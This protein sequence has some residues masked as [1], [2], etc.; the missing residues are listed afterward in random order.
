MELHRQAFDRINQAKQIELDQ[1]IAQLKLMQQQYQSNQEKLA[2]LSKK[3]ENLHLKF[4]VDKTA[5]LDS[6]MNNVKLNTIQRM[7]DGYNNEVLLNELN[8]LF[9][10]ERLLNA[11]NIQPNSN[12]P[13]F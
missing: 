1:L 5:L 10:D 13:K 2:S 8:Y 11:F 12:L 3:Q 7:V 4:Q 6:I 9:V